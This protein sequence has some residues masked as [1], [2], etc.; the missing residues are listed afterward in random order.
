M[1]ASCEKFNEPSVSVKG[2]FLEQLSN[3]QLLKDLDL[4]SCLLFLKRDDEDKS[5]CAL[6]FFLIYHFEIRN[7]E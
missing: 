4:Q 6:P 1:S 2:E 7:F 3:Y 5:P